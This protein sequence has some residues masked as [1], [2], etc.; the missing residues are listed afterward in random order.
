[1]IGEHYGIETRWRECAAEMPAAQAQM[2]RY[3]MRQEHGVLLMGRLESLLLTHLH[4][5]LPP[6]LL[7]KALRHLHTE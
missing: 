6:S 1:M 2:L 7:D 4:D 5:V 3:R